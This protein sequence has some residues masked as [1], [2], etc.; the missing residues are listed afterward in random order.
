MSPTL[1]AFF[2]ELD[3]YDG[4]VPLD[5]LERRL[6]ALDL[7][8]DD[9]REF[10]RFSPDQYRRNLIHEGPAYQALILCWANGQRSPIH[11]HRGSSCGV[12][13]IHGTATETL[14]K[15]GA[16]G[17]IIPAGTRELPQGA[18]CGSYDADIHEMSNL[19]PGGGNLVTLH[20]YSPPL[21]VMGT[22]S[23]TGTTVGEFEDP[24]FEPAANRPQRART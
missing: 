23:I 1:S 11:D 17:R 6:R 3:R 16:N 15:R 22:Y 10:A 2:E 21:L 5:E 12:Q 19:Q 7:G 9:V 24:I 20:I 13:V 8:L 14:F 4:S 18:V